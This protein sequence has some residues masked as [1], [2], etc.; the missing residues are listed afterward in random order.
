MWTRDS[1]EW[2]DIEL[3]SFCNIK[4][5]GCLRQESFERVES[6]LNK[7]HIKL[8]DLKK[9]IPT[10]EYLPNLQ[11]INFCGSVDEP[12]T[13][14]EIL[15]IVD[16]FGSIVNGKSENA[17]VNIATN[18]STKTPEFWKEL[19]KKRC[20][21][22]FGIDGIDQESL[23]KYRVGSNFK[24][25]QEN[26]RAFIKAGGHA[27]WQFIVFEHNEHLLEQAKQMSIDEGFERFRII[28][29]HRSKNGEIKK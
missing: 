10:P 7:S 6:I 11:Y 9:W 17:G 21:A 20:S 12:T 3:T 27:Q 13:H 24:K 26:W 28:Y 25:V 22:F 16:Y 2:L 8:E 15:E 4:C 5:P 1:I 18:G 14:P 29:S 23:Q 19:G